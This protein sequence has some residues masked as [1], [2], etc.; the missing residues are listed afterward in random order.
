MKSI[1]EFLKI[2]PLTTVIL[3]MIAA[4]SYAQGIE[5]PVTVTVQN[6]TPPQPPTA[7]KSLPRR[8]PRRPT[9]AP[10]RVTVMRSEAEIS[11]YVVTIIHR[12][13]GL[14][15][16]RM[17]L[18]QGEHGKV[19][20]I[21]PQT[22]T[23]NAHAT[24]IAG[25]LMRDG[26]TIVAR[27]PQAAAEI[28]ASD[29]QYS[30]QAL[31]A[32]TPQAAE[33]AVARATLA[34]SK[35]DA[36]LTVITGEGRRFRARYIG[37]DGPTGLSILQVNAPNSQD[38]DEDQAVKLTEGEQV[39]LFAPEPATP[40]GE[41]VPGVTYVRV[42]KTDAKVAKI[43]RDKS[44]GLDRLTLR[45]GK[46]S[47]D[48]VGG[49]VCDNSGKSVGIIDRIDGND[50][51]V[52]PA[53]TV[54]AATR[55]VLER[56]TNVPRPLLGVVG[57]AAGF[58]TK[59]DFLSHGWNEAQINDFVNR[60]VG[61]LLTTVLPGTPAAFAN[62]KAGD[63]I[64]KVNDD[65]VKTA[66]EFSSQLMK[67]G[68][69]E[70]V[71]FLVRR[72]SSTT[73]VPVEVKLGGSFE[74]FFEYRFEVPKISTARSA[75]QKFGLETMALSRKSAMGLGAQSG[76]VVVSVKPKSAAERAGLKE[77]DVIESIDGR[78]I[79]EGTLFKE[80]TVDHQKK[81][82][83]SVVRDRERKQLTLEAVD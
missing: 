11:P 65:D 44:G 68:S 58:S 15:M 20:A 22:L 3:L 74:P 2:F 61:I 53:E 67:C 75:F 46:L 41:P 34:A 56:Q 45:A 26:K 10:A 77:G 18:R 59:A 32:T 43:R 52:V 81:H 4:A 6:P 27:L 63:V 72:P 50:A 24:I 83:V 38:S 23:N 25:W 64:V 29:F 40:T 30:P 8:A 57:E 13:S 28:E 76:L 82:V 42:A 1:I 19:D 51:Q 79:R 70:Q 39:K 12:L 9:P 14:Q 49:I 66:E 48:L 5:A 7:E 36:D 47:T 33:A 80:T 16:L 62:L 69:G 17:M 71:K 31:K 35:I 55:R 54:R 37:L 21:D 60:Q 78:M 73:P